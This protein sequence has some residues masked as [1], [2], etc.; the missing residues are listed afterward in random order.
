MRIWEEVSIYRCG[1]MS[2][3][4]VTPG[5]LFHLQITSQGARITRSHCLVLD[6]ELGG[7][8]LLFKV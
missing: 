5:C 3:A 1:H 2:I 4:M 7:G 8:G 6:S